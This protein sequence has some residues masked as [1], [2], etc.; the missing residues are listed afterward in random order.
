MRK[1]LMSLILTACMTLSLSPAVF[2]ATQEELDQP[3][4]FIKQ[5]GRGTCTLA[6]TTMMLRRTAM[7]RGDEDWNGITQATCQEAFWLGGR[8]LPYTFEYDGITVGHEWLPGGTANRQVLIDLLA[9]HPEGIVLHARCVPHGILLTD[10][11][12]GVFYC[13]DSAQHIPEG[14]ISIEEAYGTRVENSSAYWYVTSPAVSVE[15]ETP[16]LTLPSQETTPTTLASLTAQE[17]EATPQSTSC[18]IGQ[19]LAQQG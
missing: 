15:P 8:G 3:E 4:V 6:A 19:A 7:L 11:T 10:Y 5:E 12:D 18:L 1:K 17:D 9:E 14:R 13:A 2:A 16:Q